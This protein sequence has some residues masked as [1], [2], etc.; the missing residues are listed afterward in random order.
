[1]SS[2]YESAHRQIEDLR[3]EV[4]QLSKLP[5]L[6][7]QLETIV[8]SNSQSVKG[9][10][11]SQ[12]AVLR[13]IQNKVIEAES[14]REEM[15]QALDIRDLKVTSLDENVTQLKEKMTVDAVEQQKAFNSRFNSLS[16]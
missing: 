1:M 10:I 8:S 13:K 15:R 4:N 3:R 12:D 7:T 16:E 6:L 2:K 5:K 11:E 9:S 14:I